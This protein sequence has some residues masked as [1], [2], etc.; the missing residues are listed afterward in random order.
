MYEEFQIEE[1]IR[2]RIYPGE[3]KDYV[4]VFAGGT[5]IKQSYY[6][7]FLEYISQTSNLPVI[8]FDYRSIGESKFKELQ[9]YDLELYDWRIDIGMVLDYTRKQYPGREIIYMAHSFGGQFLGVV[10]DIKDIKK[11]IF[12]A[13]QNAYWKNYAKPYTYWFFWKVIT[14]IISLFF[15]YYPAKKIG[16]GEDM[17]K[18]IVN[19]WKRY[20]MR[21]N[22]FFDDP[23]F[24]LSGYDKIELPLTAFK[25][26]DDEWGCRG[27][28]VEFFVDRYPNTES[29]II[30]VDPKDHGLS[31]IGHNGFFKRENL[32]NLIIDELKICTCLP[33][34]PNFHNLIFSKSHRMDYFL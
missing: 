3:R 9:E 20:C 16:M 29:K 23:E 4:I 28:A 30:P 5:G 31:H 1:I 21:P 8:S 7:N 13:V 17:P 2:G 18:G 12:I 32:W 25:I 33:P 10:E 14:P 6:G 26:I 27:N 19:S 22:Y 34:Y 15:N 11:L 24:D